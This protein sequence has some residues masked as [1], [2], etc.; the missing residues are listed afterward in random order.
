[1]WQ[2]KKKRQKGSLGADWFKD[3]PDFC[4]M[5]QLGV[6]LLPLDG[7][8]AV[9]AAVKTE[10][11]YQNDTIIADLHVVVIWLQLQEFLS[12]FLYYLNFK[13]PEGFN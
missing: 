6:F 3:C 9:R 8:L 12:S 5:K 10:L 7:M 4:S 1:M 2:K 13:V 11:S